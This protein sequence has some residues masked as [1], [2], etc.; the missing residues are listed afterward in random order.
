MTSSRYMNTPNGQAAT[1]VE[2]ELTAEKDED[3]S[4]P[5]RVDLMD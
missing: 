4:K 1:L 5:R 2:D 3:L